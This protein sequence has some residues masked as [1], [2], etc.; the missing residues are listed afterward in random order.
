MNKVYNPSE[1]ES[2]GEKGSILRKLEKELRK[3]NIEYLQSQVQ[4]DQAVITVLKQ[5]NQ[6][7]ENDIRSL[8]QQLSASVNAQNDSVPTIESL[9]R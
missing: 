7:Y 2:E 5:Q 4:K 3:V 1:S 6:Q 8:E 9:K